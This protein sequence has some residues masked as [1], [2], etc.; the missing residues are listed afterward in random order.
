M[1]ATREWKCEFD[2]EDRPVL[3]FDRLNDAGEQHNQVEEPEAAEVLGGL[4]G[5][6]LAHRSATADRFAITL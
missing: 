3:L 4:R 1:I 2:A 5:L 6:L